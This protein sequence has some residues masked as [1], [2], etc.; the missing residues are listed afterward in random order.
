MM[1]RFSVLTTFTIVA[2]LAA[3]PC[4]S[5]QKSEGSPPGEKTVEQ[6]RKNI[7]VLKGLPAS[8]LNLVMDDIATS[9][10]VRCGFCHSGE[11]R[12][13]QFEKD[14]KAEK[15]TARKMIQMVMNLNENSFG[16][17]EVI[18]CF[19][20]HHG[21]TEPASMMPLPQPPV[22]PAPEQSETEPNL[23]DPGRVVSML[24][25]ALGGSDA[26]NKITSR[27]TKGVAIDAEGNESPYELL[28]AAPDK[29]LSSVTMR[30]GM[31]FAH[32]FNG[33][34]GWM[35]SPRG[36]RELPS[37]AADELRRDASLSP[38]TRLKQLSA[39]LHVVD[40]D[41]VDG[42]T[43]YILA[44]PAGD[45]LT[46]RYYI[47]TASGL[48]LRRE[49]VTETMIGNIPEQEDYSDYR[50]VDGV[51]IPFAIR[52]SAVDPRDNSLHRIS[53]VEQN[54][55][56]DPKKFDPPASE[57]RSGGRKD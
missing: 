27:L 54:V 36:T 56:L 37:S 39:T 12:E 14:D 33:S 1:A 55:T 51:K 20:C 50:S 7:Q 17:R 47:D 52:L 8:R 9:L 45:H 3:A 30:E 46:E 10:G 13:L 16:G 57:P 34:A 35:S 23:P 28:Q 40:K 43:A 6:V 48:L 44:S 22:R 2:L 53:S 42:S 25:T 24:E 11:G 49:V 4:Y 5:F 29:M 21:S 41:T 15:R 38:L 18:T 31:T 26:L 32:G 19:T